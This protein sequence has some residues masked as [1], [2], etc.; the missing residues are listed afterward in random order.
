MTKK[1]EQNDERL[2]ENWKWQNDYEF[3]NILKE[4]QTYSFVEK[5]T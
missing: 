5:Y 2:T 1:F 4:I 3:T